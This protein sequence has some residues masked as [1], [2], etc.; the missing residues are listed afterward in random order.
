MVLKATLPQSEWK[1]FR[2]VIGEVVEIEPNPDKYKQLM[3][4]AREKWFYNGLNVLE[5]IKT[6]PKDGSERIVWLIFFY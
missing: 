1:N 4:T 3:A 2:D 6:N 5:T